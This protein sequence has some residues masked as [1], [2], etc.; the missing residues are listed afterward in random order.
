MKK[1]WVW[2]G[3]AVVVILAVVLIVTQIRKEEKEIKIGV[4]GPFSGPASMWGEQLRRG[5]ELAF[6]ELST[7]E[8]GKI[9]LLY[10]DSEADPRKA[11][12]ALQKLISIN[13]V[14]V[15][16]GPLSSTEVLATAPIAEKAKVVLLTPTAP[17]K[18]IT[19]AGDYIF[20]IYPSDEKRS[21]MLANYTVKELH[22]RHV[23]IIY[24]GDEFGFSVKDEYIREL[25]KLGFNESSIIAE[26]YEPG[27]SDFRT[28]I[29]KVKK[30]NP[31]VVL[32]V[33]HSRELGFIVKQ[34]YEMNFKPQFLSTADFENPEVLKIAGRAAEGVI[35]GSIVF[36]IQSSN[37]I[38]RTFRERYQKFFNTT[39]NPGIVTALCYDAFR[40]IYHAIKQAGVPTSD[41]IKQALYKIK[42]FP[43]VTGNIT[44]DENGDVSKP[45]GLKIVR[46]GKFEILMEQY[47]KEIQQ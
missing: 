19:K 1:F 14:Q 38:V 27:V 44:F 11:V 8:K 3:I 15:V 21:I 45:W 18:D 41:N 40:I 47:P 12:L 31:Q 2:I 23:G 25:K 9:R 4:I 7:N 34:A 30:I 35:Y 37:P 17:H 43:G 46:N 28:V 42:D 32:L 36:N 22:A 26:S 5:V 29:S 13:K 6:N 39:E 10:E 33:G 24:R 16:I 20:R